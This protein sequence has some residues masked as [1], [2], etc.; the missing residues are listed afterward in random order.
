VEKERKENGVV[1]FTD[2]VKRRGGK[3][4]AKASIKVCVDGLAEAQG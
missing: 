2:A 4:S 3:G 1:G